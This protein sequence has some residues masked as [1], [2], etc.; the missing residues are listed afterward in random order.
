MLTIIDLWN[1]RPRCDGQRRRA[2]KR[3]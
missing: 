2:D 3:S 1:S